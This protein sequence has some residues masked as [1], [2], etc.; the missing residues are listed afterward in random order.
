MDGTLY[1]DQFYLVR[2]DLYNFDNFTPTQ[3]IISYSEIVVRGQNP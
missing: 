3:S 1:F 2:E